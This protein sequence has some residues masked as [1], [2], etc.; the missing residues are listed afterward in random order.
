MSQVPCIAVVIEGGLVQTTLIEDW[1]GDRPPP[2]IVIVDYDKDGAADEEL[3]EFV[4]GN[5]VVAA[6]CHVE[7]PSAYESFDRPAL[8]PRA[9]LAALEEAEGA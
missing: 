1:P 4:I 2:H 8:S 7:V 9:V 5:E 6:L 3:T